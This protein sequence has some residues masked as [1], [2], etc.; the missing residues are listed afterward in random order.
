MAAVVSLCASGVGCQTSSLQNRQPDSRTAAVSAAVCRPVPPLCPGHAG[1]PSRR[2][3]RRPGLALG[4]GDRVQFTRR[5]A[6]PS[7][8]AASGEQWRRQRLA[9]G[10]ASRRRKAGERPARGRRH[11]G[12]GARSAR[13]REP[14]VHR[15]AGPPAL[16]H[17]LQQYA[18]RP[19]AHADQSAHAE[20]ADSAARRTW[21]HSRPPSSRRRRSSP[22]RPRPR[23]CAKQPLPPYVVEPPDILLI[24]ASTGRHAG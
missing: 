4:Y 19:A 11:A 1:R 16:H 9:A 2:Q 18:Q 12:V 7:G 21:S 13:W 10:A 6:A 3:R 24:E 22:T 15:N 8:R 14:R 20:Q 23:E 17:R 5:R